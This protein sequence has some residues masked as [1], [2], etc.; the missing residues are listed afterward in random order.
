MSKLFI[1][2]YQASIKV[3]GKRFE[4]HSIENVYEEVNIEVNNA[5]IEDILIVL[6]NDIPS[7]PMEAKSLE[8]SNFFKELDVKA[9]SFSWW[10]RTQT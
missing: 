7:A 5:L 1:D 9:K 8:V 2:L 10:K 6:I 4:I 3:K